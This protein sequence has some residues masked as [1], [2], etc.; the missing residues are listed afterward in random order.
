[1]LSMPRK[2][3]FPMM[4]RSSNKHYDSYYLVNNLEELLK[5]LFD[6]LKWWDS[7]GYFFK[8]HEP[9]VDEDYEDL[10]AISE[11]TLQGLPEKMR[12]EIRTRIAKTQMDRQR[13]EKALEEYDFVRKFIDEGDYM[14]SYR[15]QRRSD[16]AMMIRF[17]ALSLVNDYDVGNNQHVEEIN[18]I[19]YKDSNGTSDAE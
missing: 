8:P 14:K 15:Y 12:Q 3:S 16:G 7:E 5:A 17:H 19:S 6:V 2:D 18:Y 11:E 1:M 4:V 10:L 13:Y 9:A